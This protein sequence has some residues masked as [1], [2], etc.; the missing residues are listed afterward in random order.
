MNCG[1]IKHLGCYTVNM[2]IGFGINAPCAGDY[3]FEIFTNTGAFSTVVLPFEEGAPLELPFTFSETGETLIKIQVPE[4][5]AVPGWH[6]FTTN[7]GACTWAVN[8]VLPVCA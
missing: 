5:A 4:C 2:P 7:D 3:T 8:G 6:Y 1:C